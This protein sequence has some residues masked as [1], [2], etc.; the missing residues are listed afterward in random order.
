LDGVVD[1]EFEDRGGLLSEG[2][3]GEEYK[4]EGSVSCDG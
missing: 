2:G 3:K 4:K 1:G